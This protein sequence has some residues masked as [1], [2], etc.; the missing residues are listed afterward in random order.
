MRVDVALAQ[1]RAAGLDRADAEIL[2]AHCSGRSRVQ[3]FAYPEFQL[4]AA[5][6]VRFEQLV[7]QRAD[8]VPVAYLTGAQE[9]HGLRLGVGP[10]VLVPRPETELLVAFALDHAASAESCRV[11]DLGTGSGAIALAIASQRPLWTVHAS[12]RSAPALAR[13]RS[14]AEALGLQQVHWHQGNWLDAVPGQHFDLI[15]SN[16][17]Y[18]DSADTHLPSLRHEPRGALVAGDDALAD[19]RTLVATAMAHLHP[20]G[21][22]ALEH[23]FDQAA[24]VRAELQAHGYLQIDSQRDLAGHE[25]ISF[26]RS[27]AAPAGNSKASQRPHQ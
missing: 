4:D 17:P 5:C 25:R 26:G 13:A 12:D 21:W 11:L 22:L 7:R 14:N 23:G 9:F 19:L 15:L 6:C 2:L 27:P 3:L 1:A 20:G 16:P 24:A 10:E 8:A 18:L